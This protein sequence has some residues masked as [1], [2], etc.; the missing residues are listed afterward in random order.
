MLKI[1]GNDVSIFR[2]ITILVDGVIDLNKRNSIEI[3]SKNTACH[4]ER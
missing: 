3:V 2:P 4:Y 1:Y